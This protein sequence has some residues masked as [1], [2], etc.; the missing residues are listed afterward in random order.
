MSIKGAT[1]I[2][3]EPC[4]V[5]SSENH[6]LRKKVLD[7]VKPEFSHL[8]E[9]IVVATDL[10]GRMATIRE[11]YE[12][13][14][15][16]KM[17]KKAA[18]LREGVITL[19]EDVSMADLQQFCRKM[20][21]EF[22][23]KVLQLHVHEDEGHFNES[24]EWKKNRHAHIILDYFD[25]ETGKTFRPSPQD[26][27]EMQTMLADCLHMQRG[28][29]SDVKHLNAIQYKNQEQIK[30]YR[31]VQAVLTKLV[32]TSEEIAQ[33]KEIA[34]KNG[35]KIDFREPK[36]DSTPEPKFKRSGGL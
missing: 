22:P 36:H 12:Q 1:S 30:Q 26:M 15:G 27:A 18:P 8:N 31:L 32:R 13:K 35:L 5:G 23:V 10:V 16:R 6:N 4:K 7:Y 17:Q 33:L 20:E 21:Q 14:V 2:H 28:E 9:S 29:N 25:Y 24:G 19:N 3:I 34:A 11:I